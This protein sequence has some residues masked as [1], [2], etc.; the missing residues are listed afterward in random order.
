MAKR[1]QIVT[2]LGSPHYGNSNTRALVKGFV[3][4][5][6]GVFELDWW[7]ARGW[8]YTH[9]IKQLAARPIPDDFNSKERLLTAW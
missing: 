9:S 3:E 2:I 6:A 7:R 4:D 8:L 1:F 5:V